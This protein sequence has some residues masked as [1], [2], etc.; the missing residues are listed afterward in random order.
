MVN[1]RSVVDLVA[2]VLT[3]LTGRHPALKASGGT[4][5]EWAVGLAMHTATDASEAARDSAEYQQQ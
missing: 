4:E 2:L 1:L 3:E 5:M